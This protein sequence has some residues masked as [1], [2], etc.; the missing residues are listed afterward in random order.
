[1][2]NKCHIPQLFLKLSRTGIWVEYKNKSINHGFLLPKSRIGS[3]WRPSN[4]RTDAWMTERQSPCRHMTGH[5]RWQESMSDIKYV[6]ISVM[7]RH[8]Q[9]HFYISC[10]LYVFQ[11]FLRNQTS[12]SLVNFILIFLLQILSF[13]F[14]SVYSGTRWKRKGGFLIHFVPS[15]EAFWK[16]TDFSFELWTGL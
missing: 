16:S 9:S 10:F 12:Q 4:P 15:W 6:S 1:M 11:S 8:T 7:Q 14:T 5:N 2:A 3:S 13:L